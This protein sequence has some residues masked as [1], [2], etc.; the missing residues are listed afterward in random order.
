ML[1][2]LFLWWCCWVYVV[3]AVSYGFFFFLEFGSMQP[4][5]MMSLRGRGWILFYFI[6]FFNEGI[7]CH[8]PIFTSQIFSGIGMQNE[9]T[10]TEPVWPKKGLV[11][12][13]NSQNM[14]GS[15]FLEVWGG[16]TKALTGPKAWFDWLPSNHWI[17]HIKSFDSILYG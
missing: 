9:V 14:A 12:L 17:K 11:T 7:L 1:L 13:K 5:K 2:L 8:N 10:R 3:V 16:L 4:L 6:F 15:A